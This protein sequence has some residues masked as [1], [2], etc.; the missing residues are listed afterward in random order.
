MGGDP[1]VWFYDK[2]FPGGRLSPETEAGTDREFIHIYEKLKAAR[3]P[4]LR[5]MLPRG[6]N[7]RL[8]PSP[9]CKR[10]APRFRSC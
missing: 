3:R 4:F 6:R 5:N 1:S 2:N 8:R 10:T 9:D 7:L